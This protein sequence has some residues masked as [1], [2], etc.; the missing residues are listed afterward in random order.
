MLWLYFVH[1]NFVH[2]R[3]ALRM[4]PAHCMKWSGSLI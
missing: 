4:T 1:Y 3:K 2:V